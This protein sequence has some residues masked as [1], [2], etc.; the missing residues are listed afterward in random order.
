[1]YEEIDY[2][3]WS[4]KT[5]Y[6]DR[7]YYHERREHLNAHYNAR[8]ALREIFDIAWHMDL[9]IYNLQSASKKRYEEYIKNEEVLEDRYIKQGYGVALELDIL[10]YYKNFIGY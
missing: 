10:P 5:R 4:V 3:N 9:N 2:T 1:M 7:E 6:K 8:R